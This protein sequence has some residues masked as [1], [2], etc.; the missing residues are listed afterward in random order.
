MPRL[1]PP[2]DYLVFPFPP[3]L[4]LPIRLPFFKCSEF[5]ALQRKL[6]EAPV[7]F[8][9]GTPFSHDLSSIAS[10]K[11]RLAFLEE[12]RK[13]DQKVSAPHSLPFH[14]GEKGKG[15]SFLRDVFPFL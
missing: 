1:P 15:G 2:H 5:R 9:D 14:W 8:A 6:E 4:S 12:S 11:K 10:L 3:S 13:N 7:N